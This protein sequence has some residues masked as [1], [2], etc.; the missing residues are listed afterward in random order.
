M[1]TEEQLATL[2]VRLKDLEAQVGQL[3]EQQHR[4]L[5]QPPQ[6]L[7]VP[8]QPLRSP[9]LMKSDLGSKGEPEM[10]ECWRIGFPTRR[11]L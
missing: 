3:A 9:C 6:V 5:Q 11:E 10:T 1:T 7:P 4:T 2:T 8:H